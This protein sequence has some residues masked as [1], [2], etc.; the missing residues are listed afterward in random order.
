MNV[1]GVSLVL[2]L[3]AFISIDMCDSDVLFAFYW[4]LNSKADV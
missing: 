1:G 3:N 4:M 2:T